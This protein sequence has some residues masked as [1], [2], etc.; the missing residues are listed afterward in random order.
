[1]AE[2]Q[3]ALSHRPPQLLGRSPRPGH[4]PPGLGP[5]QHRVVPAPAAAHHRP[6]RAEHGLDARSPPVASRIAGAEMGMV[7][8]WMSTRVLGQYDLLVVE[9]ENPEDQDIVYYVGPNIIGLEKRFAFPP[10]EFRHLP[11]TAVSVRG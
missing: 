2:E 4:R 3:V 8:G 1:M 7:L 9:D 11:S 10:R 5:G 6:A